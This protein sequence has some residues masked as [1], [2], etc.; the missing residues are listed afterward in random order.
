MSS[1]Q[2]AKYILSFK[3]FKGLKYVDNIKNRYKIGR[4]LGEGS[5]G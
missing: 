4:V 1:E 3:E 2:K 5:F